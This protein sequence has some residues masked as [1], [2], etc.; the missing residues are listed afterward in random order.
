[1]AC[2][3]EFDSCSHMVEKEL[4]MLYSSLNRQPYSE[5]SVSG[6]GIPYF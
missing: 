4:K 3:A 5:R 2:D 1:M 6:D